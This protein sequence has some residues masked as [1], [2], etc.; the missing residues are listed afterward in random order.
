ML[1]PCRHSQPDRTVINV[2]LVIL[3]RLRQRRIEPH[4]S[5]REYVMKTVAGSDSLFL[6][7]L[8]LLY[9][10]GVIEYRPRED[11]IELLTAHEA[12]PPVHQ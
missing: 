12:L 10:L 7:A 2:C 1:R 3:V 4:H 11:A 9:L 6:P 8:D 5:L